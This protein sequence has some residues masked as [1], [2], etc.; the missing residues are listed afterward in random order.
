MD[1]IT[2]LENIEKQ[3]KVIP[4]SP[5]VYV[6]LDENNEVI[7][8]GK[9]KVL[10]N[11]VKSH[12]AKSTDFSKSRIIRERGVH[13]E[14]HE[15]ATE[16]EAL[17]LEYN[18]IQ[19]H[20]PILNT[21]YTDGKTYPY[22][23]V[24]TGET[25]PRFVMTRE[26]NNDESVYLGPFSDVGAV[27]RSLKYVLKL[28]PVA[29]CQKEIHLGDAQGWA[30]T[31]IRRRTRQCMRPCEIEVD[32]KEYQEGVQQVIH[33]IEGKLPRIV[34]DVE[35]KMKKASE[36]L[37][38]ERAAKYRDV[39]RSIQRTMQRQQ[40]FLEDVKD[41]FVLVESSNSK[42]INFTLQKTEDNRVVRRDSHSVPLSDIKASHDASED[43][44]RIIDECL[45]FIRTI[46]KLD[47]ENTTSEN[48]GE[49]VV[50]SVYSPQIIS[51]LS[52]YDLSVRLPST[53]LDE[54]LIT[55]AKYHA[56]R[57]LQRR[58]LVTKDK[59][60][61]S[62]R[63]EDLRIILGL[64]LPPY[65]I[66]TFDVSTLMGTNN[67]ASCVRFL[68]GKPLKKGYR[69]FKIQT[70]DHQDD[71]ASMEE[72]VYRR[73][74]EV[75]DGVDPKGLPIP[76]LIII[77]GGPEQL[78]RAES[79]LRRN[80][81]DIAVVG[82]AKREEEIYLPGVEIPLNEDN[83]RPGMLLV[84]AARDEAHR[85]AVTYQRKLRQKEGITSILDTIEGIGPKRKQKLMREYKTVASLAK[86]SS[87]TLSSKLG[88]PSKVASEVIAACRAFTTAMTDKRRR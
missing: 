75:K 30:K 80:S 52:I 33:F 77:D 66:D 84:T 2:R 40:V 48:V 50:A 54:Q 57:Q 72:V 29:D 34:T 19:E 8:V 73:Y 27:K 81:L 13:I 20:Q 71:F 35:L 5:G 70:V 58:L 23:E 24:T 76:D 11:R 79:A 59:S 39:M 41:G 56:N 78:K 60:L 15:V 9:A 16:N 45:E 85:F 43:N 65:I 21:R 53:D 86:E 42:E 28:F 82:L 18:M 69:R 7:Y 31:C 37:E 74:R 10:A 47:D 26:R 6:I 38:F 32:E 12:F 14:V 36:D 88:I 22:L 51:V 49:L 64:E 4:Q 25:W 62:K 87:E 63:V 46:L 61:P 68:N 83:N 55:M 44:Q 3:L 1:D 67:V 17:L